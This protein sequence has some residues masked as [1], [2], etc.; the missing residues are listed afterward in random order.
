MAG[1]PIHWELEVHRI[2]ISNGTE[3]AGRVFAVGTYGKQE[4]IP[5]DFAMIEQRFKRFVQ[6]A[7]AGNACHVAPAVQFW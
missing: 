1:E 5:D 6:S 2:F 7:F 4:S 3:K